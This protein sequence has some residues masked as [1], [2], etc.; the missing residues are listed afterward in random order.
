MFNEAI[1]PLSLVCIAL[2]MAASRFIAVPLTY[3]C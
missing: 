3:L 1:V 2:Y